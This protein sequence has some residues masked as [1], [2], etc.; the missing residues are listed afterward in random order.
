MNLADVI[1]NPNDRPLLSGVVSEAAMSQSVTQ[2]VYLPR[3]L[4][5]Y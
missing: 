2:V 1:T 4:A 5:K 3:P